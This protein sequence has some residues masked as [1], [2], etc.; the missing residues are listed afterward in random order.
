MNKQ[1]KTPHFTADT[2]DRVQTDNYDPHIVPAETAARKEREGDAYKTLPTEGNSDESINTTD[3]YTVDQEGLLNNYA[4]EPEMYINE[5][6][7]LREEEAELAAERAQEIQ[8][9]SEDEEGKLT[10]EEDMRHRG[11]GM[12]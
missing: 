11:Q 3:G 4:I 8:S 12:V 1:D 2:S 9:L 7:D 6:G 5:P 10:M